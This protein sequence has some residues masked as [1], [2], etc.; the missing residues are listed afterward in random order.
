LVHWLALTHVPGLGGA[1]LR[2]LLE[3]FGSIEAIFAADPAALATIPRLRPEAI[4]ALQTI[5]LE[6]VEAELAAL[7]AAGITLLTW[8]DPSYPAALHDL[9]D[10][11]PVLFVRGNLLPADTHAVAIIGSR[12]ASEQSLAIARRLAAG[13][14]TVGLTVV[15]GLAMGIDTA[16]HCGALDAPGGRTLAVLGSGVHA[17]HPRQNA[18]LAERIIRR[19]ALLSELRP[20]APPLGR[21]LMARD[22]IIGA[23]GR[24]V[25]VVEAGEESGSLDTARRARRLRRLIL[26]CP[27]SP[28]TDALLQA[29]AEPLDPV[30]ADLDALAERLRQS[31]LPPPAVEQPRLL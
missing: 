24:A 10:P 26:A 18:D 9:S 13:L 14:A 12:Q 11:P 5:P 21:N 6:T 8:E 17:V 1:T 25:I 15:S 29:G 2:R 7:R 28:G 16:A 30:T 4:A 27:G 20:D 23:L 31:P 19:G 3:R 22:R